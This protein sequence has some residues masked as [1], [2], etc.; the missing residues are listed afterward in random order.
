MIF[1][2]VPCALTRLIGQ[3]QIVATESFRKVGATVSAS[4]VITTSLIRPVN[5][6]DSLPKANT[7]QWGR[8]QHR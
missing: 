1:I 7:V 4:A 5:S 3:R 8:W 2:L 6:S